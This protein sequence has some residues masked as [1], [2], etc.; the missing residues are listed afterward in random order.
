MQNFS[1]QTEPISNLYWLR[2]TF[3]DGIPIDCKPLFYQLKNKLIAYNKGLIDNIIKSNGGEIITPMETDYIEK[4]LAG[5]TFEYIPFFHNF[6]ADGFLD[7]NIE[8]GKVSIFY[9]TNCPLNRRRYTK[10]H[11][12]FHFVQLLDM[13]FLDFFDNLLINSD[14]PNYLI[15]KLLEKST[16]KATAMY[17]MPNEYFIK[18]Y[19]EIKN[20]DELAR[21]FGV[22]K[23][24]LC[25]RIQEC[26]L[27]YAN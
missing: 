13:Q 25:Y 3:D 11:E 1:N 2:Q 14:F 19:N 10:I 16:D 22:S 23:Q 21:I 8:A 27:M 26:G 15:V 6:G 18:K 12:L 17:L 24:S 9:N 7:Y 20:V 5:F 4:Y